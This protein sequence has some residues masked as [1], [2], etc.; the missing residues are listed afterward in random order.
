M[1]QPYEVFK[2]IKTKWKPEQELE[3][4]L[5]N[6]NKVTIFSCGF[7]A[8]LCDTGGTIGM[9]AME[10]FLHQNRKEVVLAKVVVSCCSE[11]IM[12]Q[13]VKRHRH[14]I[15]ASDALV[16]L[17]CSAGVKSAYLVGVGVP[18]IGALDT[19]GNTPI[20][21]QTGALAE[22]ICATCGQCV[23]S[24]TGGICPV[25]GCPLHLK[26]GPCERFNESDIICV[27]DSLRHCV[28]K[29]ISQA[30]D[31]GGL[32]KLQEVHKS[33]A[34]VVSKT[35]AATRVP[36]WMKRTSGWI[37]AHSGWLEKAALSIR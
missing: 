32:A 30:V 19:I 28:W 14:S 26:Y 22:S 35:L 23:L 9:K 1:Q 8:S 16:I 13:T 4:S 18:I 31:L 29:E 33:E 36:S 2:M 10:A 25:S 37:M 12:R 27:V 15:S 17:S 20:T 21:R 11:E 5:R 24:Y 6:F 3:Y 7:C 34:M